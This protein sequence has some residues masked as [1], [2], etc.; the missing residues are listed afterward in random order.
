M[1][2][3]MPNNRKLQKDFFYFFAL[4]RLALLFASTTGGGLLRKPIESPLNRVSEKKRKPIINESE[5]FEVE[6]L[7][8]AIKLV[9]P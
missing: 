2:S 8:T 9:G 5:I 3:R 7:H 4:R 1:K 6:Y